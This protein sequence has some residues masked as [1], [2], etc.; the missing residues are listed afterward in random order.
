[1]LGLLA[2]CQAAFAAES[3]LRVAVAGSP[4][5]VVAT[6]DGA[7]TGFAVDVWKA[8]ARDRGLAYDLVPYPT[9]P[10][11][12]A[13]VRRGAVDVAIGPI[14]ITAER[15]REVAFTQ[16]YYRASLGI[17]A[18]TRPPSAWERMRPFLSATFGFAAGCLLLLLVG[19]GFLVWVAERRRNPDQF[20]PGL[21]A[22]VGNGMWLALVT[23]TTVG[24][25]DRAPVSL[26]GRVIVG[27][28]M[29]VSMVTAST[30]TAALATV[31]T[32]S[33]VTSPAIE[34]P[35]QLAGRPVA[36][37]K[38]TTG[39]TFAAA[40]GARVR[41][42]AALDAAVAEVVARRAD[43]VVFDRPALLHFLGERPELPLR[44]APARFHSQNYGFALPLTSARL[45]DL[46]RS[47]LAFHESAEYGAVRDTWMPGAGETEGAA[48]E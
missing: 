20:P 5:F 29:L 1:M 15:A 43:A 18:S 38:G 27:V 26:P 48:S 41:R 6:A 14:S 9:V 36:V 40:V 33:H 22:G 10:E 44:A 42:V 19:V 12:L 30:L 21:L 34:R 31:F 28:W 45:H 32:V 8:L 3:P 13:A 7:R 37:V 17:L 23:M 46:N 35:D 24:Y 47:L 2:F 16:P 11:A 4:P 25:G 39:D